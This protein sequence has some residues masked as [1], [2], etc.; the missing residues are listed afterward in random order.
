MNPVGILV[1]ALG[2]VI[3]IV[4]FKGSQHRIVASL[5]NKPAKT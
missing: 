4:G 2:I 1:I 3:V 5:T